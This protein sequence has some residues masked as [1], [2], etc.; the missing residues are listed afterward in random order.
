[1]KS[2]IVMI[3]NTI[4][5]YIIPSYPHSWKGEP[6]VSVACAIDKFRRHL[7]TYCKMSVL[8]TINPGSYQ[9]INKNS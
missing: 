1:M 9:Q 6:I 7:D 8:L 4:E 2:G 5:S 3:I